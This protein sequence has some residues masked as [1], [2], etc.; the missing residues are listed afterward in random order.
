M[1]KPKA[2]L[3]EAAKTVNELAGILPEL[4]I[5]QAGSPNASARF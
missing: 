3:H 1:P 5:L 4:V 2:L